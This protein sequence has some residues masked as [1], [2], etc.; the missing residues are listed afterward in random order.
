MHLNT[1]FSEKIG[2]S[3]Q[4]GD[5]A[6][7]K[8]SE[9]STR[10]PHQSTITVNTVAVPM[11]TLNHQASPTSRS[12]RSL[13][14]ENNQL[15]SQYPLYIPLPTF[16]LRQKFRRRPLI[17]S[18][19]KRTFIASLQR[20][21]FSRCWFASISHAKI[22]N[23]NRN[24]QYHT[25]SSSKSRCRSSSHSLRLSTWPW[26]SAFFPPLFYRRHFCSP[27]PACKRKI[28]LAR[29]T[30]VA[31]PSMHLQRSSCAFRLSTAKVHS[32]TVS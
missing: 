19:S 14:T 3:A 27:V 18:S 6:V 12:K 1:L 17:Y 13:Q 25:T 5:L 28:A 29:V 15:L 21:C 9:L 7:Q 22:R 10:L 24:H 26:V 11:S 20:P 23:A 16:C 2:V 32:S 8:R 31:P 4:I 30:L